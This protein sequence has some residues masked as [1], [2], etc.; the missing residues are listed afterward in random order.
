VTDRAGIE[1]ALFRWA[2]GFDDGDVE[3]FLTSLTKDAQVTF[4]AEGA[5]KVGPITGHDDIRAFVEDRIASR[6]TRQR[7]FT[8]NILIEEQDN[9]EVTTTAYLMIVRLADTGPEIIATGVYRD[10]LVQEDG[11]W[12][13]T[14]RH[15]SSTGRPKS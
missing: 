6:E 1:N 13:I 15:L 10:R 2:R 9:G 8:T 5:N 11:A 7:H 12:R 3:T 14:E 4:E